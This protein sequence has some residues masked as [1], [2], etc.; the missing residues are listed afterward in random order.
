MKIKVK[1]K[2]YNEALRLSD[3]KHKK[4]IKPF[5]VMQA[6][7]RILS[8]FSLISV[9]FKYKKIGME[10]IGKKEPILI[11]MNHSAFIDLKIASRLLW[12]RRYNIIM[13]SDGF[14]GKSLLMKTVGCIPTQKFVSDSVLVRDIF[15]AVKKNKTSVLMY[16]EASYSFDGRATTLPESLGKLVKK[17]GVPVVAVI[18]KGAFAHDPL[19]NGLQKRRVKISAEMECLLTADQ[20]KNMPFDQINKV[21]GEKFNFD[22]F[23]WQQENNVKITEGFR[24]DYIHRVLYKCPNCQAEGDTIGEG[25]HLFCGHCGKMWELTENGFMKALNGDSEYPHIPDWYRFQRESVKKELLDGSY[26]LDC[27]VD[28]YVLTNLKA[29]YNIGGGRLTHSIDGFTLKS[30]D[31]QLFY[32]QAPELSYSLYSDFYWYEIGDVICI[33][34]GRVLYYCFPKDKKVSVAKVRLAAEELFKIKNMQ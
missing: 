18:T 27:D 9:G 3:L 7:I 32:T 15:H 10:K 12:P 30:D 11:L 17:L 20:I 2:S 26:K 5:F 13:T 14:V 23:R 8:A 34:N 22:N 24:A 21:I 33:G 31:G 4:P 29:V 28:I 6:L 1:N 16:P 19:Y 25:T